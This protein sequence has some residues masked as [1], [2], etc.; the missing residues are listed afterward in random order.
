MPEQASPRRVVARHGSAWLRA[1]CAALPSGTFMGAK[2]LT[3]SQDG[4]LSYLMA[5]I[6]GQTGRLAALMDASVLT[7]YRTAATSAAAL[8]AWG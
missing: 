7:A 8:K 2:L 1:L 6:D 4:A 5:L 3:R